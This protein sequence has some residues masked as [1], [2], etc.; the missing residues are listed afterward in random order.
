MDKNI[1]Q[2]FYENLKAVSQ[3]EI[4]IGTNKFSIYKNI[5]QPNKRKRKYANVP[6]FNVGILVAQYYGLIRK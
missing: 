1:A 5:A 6:I 3:S 2:L 4:S